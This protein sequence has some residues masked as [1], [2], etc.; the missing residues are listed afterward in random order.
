MV[1]AERNS[2]PDFVGVD[3]IHQKQ[4]EQ[5]EIFLGWA[6]AHDWNAFHTNHYDWWAFPIDMPS[7]FGFNF[8]V[9]P[10]DVRELKSKPDFTRNLTEAARLL[11]LSWGWDADLERPLDH[12]EPGQSWADWPI[13]WSKCTSSLKLFGLTKMYNSSMKFGQHLLDHGVS[14]EYLGRDLA[15]EHGLT[16]QRW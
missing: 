14:F 13:R 2:H 1:A 12:P 9:F 15:A 6:V 16:S 8:T 7:N 10:E 4:R 3:Q 11:L 5:V